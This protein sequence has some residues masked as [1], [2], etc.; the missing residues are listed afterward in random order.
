L[1]IFDL[2]TEDPSTLRFE[3]QAEDRELSSFSTLRR[4]SRLSRRLR[5]RLFIYKCQ[6]PLPARYL[7]IKQVKNPC[8]GELNSVATGKI[9]LVVILS[10]LILAGGLLSI[11]RRA[12]ATQQQGEFLISANPDSVQKDD[13]NLPR[14]AGETGLSR[15]NSELF[16]KMLL[17]VILVI[18]LG[19]AVIYV[20]KKLLPRMASQPGKQIRV[21]E[22][23]HIAPRKGLHLIQAGTRRLLIASTNETITMLADVTETAPDFATELAAQSQTRK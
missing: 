20:T 3:G 15:S 17:S 11:A 22:T 10:G 4:F 21:L 7:H 19:I 16:Y 2:T 18:A 1:S 5:P 12:T 8:I 13:A 23:A 9:K 14:Q 6:F